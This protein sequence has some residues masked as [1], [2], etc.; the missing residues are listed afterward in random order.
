MMTSPIPTSD[1]SAHT[2]P[3]RLFRLLEIV[4]GLTVWCVLILPFILAFHSPTA[5]ILFVLIFDLYW[6]IKSLNYAYILVR[7]Y[8]HVKQ[9]LATNWTKKLAETLAMHQQNPD[10]VPDWRQ[11]Y[12]AVILTA[13]KEDP[14]VLKASVQSILDTTYPKNRL[15]VVLATEGRDTAEAHAA[16]HELAQL[17][18]GQVADIFV[19][20]H[21]DDI[22]GEMKAKGANA[23]WAAKELTRHIEKRGISPA[24]V[25]VTTADADTRFIASY[26]DRLAYAFVTAPDRL[27]CA[28]QPAPMYFN[29]IWRAPF[30]SRILALGDTFWIMVE[31]V[32]D[33]RLVTFSTHAFVLQ[34]LQEID[35]WCTS[36]VNEDSRQFFR[37]SFH[38]NG[39]FRVIPLFIPVY[40]DAVL[41][42]TFPR[43]LKNLY[44][45]KQRWAYGTEHFP[46]IV[47]ESMRH[48]Q[49]PL[50]DRLAL[51]Y[52]SFEGNFT[53]ATSS[54]FIT[55]VGWLPFLLSP[56]FSNQL[57]ALNFQRFTRDILTLTWIGLFISIYLTL[58]LIPKQPGRASFLAHI[59]MAAQWIA[60]PISAL[61]F[62]SI[63]AIDAQT[64]L[65]LGKYIGFRVTE[66][67]TTP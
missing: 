32:R 25:I 55:V 38:Y 29:N 30:L 52:R 45:Q 42:N 26:F 4:P 15:I 2:Y 12:H 41:A 35:Y 10:A 36:I 63:P 16:A 9:T 39:R 28:Y 64:R 65:A 40:M 11:V 8:I 21:P 57:V 18:R 43:S 7:G 56:H 61:L 1:V 33:W 13:Y 19:T 53:W 23:T 6:L 46:Y 60:V 14:Q 67:S 48:K 58:S 27:H 66:K 62:S 34:T 22:A 37:A 24:L 54:Y 47:L 31:S 50:L 49:M 51:I 3:R 5:V 44:L 17:Y 59:G 20:E